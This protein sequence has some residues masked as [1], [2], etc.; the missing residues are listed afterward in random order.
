MFNS[1]AL[2][3]LHIDL[4]VTYLIHSPSLYRTDTD[5]PVFFVFTEA[6]SPARTPGFVV[7]SSAFM[8]RTRTSLLFLP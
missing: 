2:F 1:K 5:N 7:K 3:E 6:F 4:S 8:S